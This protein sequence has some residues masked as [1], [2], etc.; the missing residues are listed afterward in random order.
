MDEKEVPTV[1]SPFCFI[2]NPNWHKSLKMHII[3]KPS[4]LKYQ[5]KKNKP[6]AYDAF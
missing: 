4:A 1:L 6:Y 2:N 5:K 3:Y